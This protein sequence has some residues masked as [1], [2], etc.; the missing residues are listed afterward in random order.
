MASA[1][2][3][4][5][6]AQ[7][8][9]VERANGHTPNRSSRGNR[10]GVQRGPRGDNPSGQRGARRGGGLGRGNR[11]NGDKTNW[12]QRVS[13]PGNQPALSIPPSSDLDSGGSFNARLT[14]DAGTSDREILNQDEGDRGAEDEVEAEVCFI[15]ASKV[16]HNSVAPC[17]HRT[18]HI[19][20]LRLRALYKTRACAHCRV[21]KSGSSS[22]AAVLTRLA[23]RNPTS[24]YLQTIQRNA[25]RTSNRQ[26]SRKS[27]RL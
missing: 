4:T 18:C 14:K 16:E 6:A 21:I 7:P 15:C 1:L 17:N 25:M 10:R 19:C 3:A 23:R 24:S 13:G 27:M 26:I 5:P 20:A 11:A 2:E 22:G 9:L 12:S 8:D